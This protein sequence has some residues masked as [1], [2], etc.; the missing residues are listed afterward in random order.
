VFKH[1]PSTRFPLGELQDW[2]LLIEFRSNDGE[3]R[4]RELFETILSQAFESALVVDAAIAQSIQQNRDFWALRE[5][6][7]E[8]DFM[9]GAVIT[10]D[11][12]LPL[13]A[14]PAFMD[15]CSRAVLAIVPVGRVIAFGHLGDGNIHFGLLQPLGSDSEQFLSRSNE[16][17]SIIHTMALSMNGSMSAEH[18]LGFVKNDAVAQYRSQVEHDLMLTMK[19]ALDPKSTLNLGKVLRIENGAFSAC[20][21]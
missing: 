5:G 6:L 17:Q 1:F 20:K 2:Q 8:A 9:E 12:S 13:S 21:T 4:V 16:I 11:I 19:A 15:A 14:V 10:T 3:E 18:G 7:A